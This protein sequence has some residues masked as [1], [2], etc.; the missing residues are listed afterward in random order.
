MNKKPALIVENKAEFEAAKAYLREKGCKADWFED[1]VPPYPYRISFLRE[2][3]KLLGIVDS[4]P[5]SMDPNPE[6]EDYHFNHISEFVNEAKK[7]EKK[8][9]PFFVVNNSLNVIKVEAYSAGDAAN[10]F[11]QNYHFILT[12]DELRLFENSIKRRLLS[13][14]KKCTT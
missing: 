5:F 6:Y 1:F 13:L 4:S 7:H 9:V 8:K 10:I 2:E 12:E 14:D 11:G 3:N